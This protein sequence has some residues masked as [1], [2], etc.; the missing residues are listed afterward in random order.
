MPSIIVNTMHF[1]DIIT[2]KKHKI[3]IVIFIYVYN[4]RKIVYGN[5]DDKHRH[6]ERNDYGY[7]ENRFY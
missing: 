1:H 2:K 5:K 4:Q 7:E 6:M 3:H